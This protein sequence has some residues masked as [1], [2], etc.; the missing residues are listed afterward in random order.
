P[1][2]ILVEFLPKQ[3]GRLLVEVLGVGHVLDE[4]QQVPEHPAPRI[5][6]QV[7]ERQ[8]IARF[9][10]HE[11]RLGEKAGAGGSV[12]RPSPPAIRQKVMSPPRGGFTF[13]AREFTAN[14]LAQSL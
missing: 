12:R 7:A 6:Q 2:L 11:Q 8:R 13:T 1:R 3:Q 10:G 9:V 5:A 4:R 14:P